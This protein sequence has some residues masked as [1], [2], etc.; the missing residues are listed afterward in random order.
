LRLLE[1]LGV[2]YCIVVRFSGSFAKLGPGDFVSKILCSKLRARAVYVGE[3]FRFGRGAKAGA[4][5]L[6]DFL[7]P[8]GAMVKVFK[9]MKS[10]GNAI[11]SSLIRRLIQKGDIS[12]AGKLLLRPVSVYGNV[13]AG[14]GRGRKL[15]FPTANISLHHEIT[16]P[17]GVYAVRVLLGREKIF[18]GICYIGTRPT[19]FASNDLKEIEVHIFGFKKNIYGSYIEAQF[20][21]KIRDQKTFKN[22][23]LLISQIKKDIS[24]A[25]KILA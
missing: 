8:C 3:N 16:P 12:S 5:D 20:I 22:A 2:D 11:S 1:E 18:K 10:G 13:V 4:P 7:R 21:K 19:F 17:S 9:T 24:A 23:G 15:G 14:T 25:E 6:A